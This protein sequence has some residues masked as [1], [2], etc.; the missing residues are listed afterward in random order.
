MTLGWQLANLVLNLLLEPV[1]KV[2]DYRLVIWFLRAIQLTKTA[3]KIFRQFNLQGVVCCSD[4]VDI[5]KFKIVLKNLLDIVCVG[6]NEK[7]D[8]NSNATDQQPLHLSLL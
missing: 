5:K 1:S 2:D 3:K 8:S 6:H 4:R 7:R